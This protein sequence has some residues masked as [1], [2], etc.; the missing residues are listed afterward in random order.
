VRNHQVPDTPEKLAYPP[1]G[2]A[3]T[4]VAILIATAILSYTDRQ[5]LTLLVDPIRR[6]LGINDTEMSLLI[7]SAFAVIY[8]VAGIP[9]GYLVDRTSRRNLVACGVAIWSLATLA[10]GLSRTFAEIFSARVFVGLGEAVLSPAA[11]SLISD[12]FPPSRRG[13][14]VGLYLSGIAMGS[15]TAILI[16]GAVLHAVDL[17]V[18]GATPLGGYAPWRLVLLLSG[19]AGVAW[20]LAI[21]IIREPVRRTGELQ[22][23]TAADGAAARDVLRWTR[24]APIYLIVGLASLV[25]NAVGAWSPSLLIR[26]FVRDPGQIGIQLGILITV[27][28]GAGILLGGVLA[29]RVGVRGGLAAKLRVCL[30]AALLILPASFLLNA[31]HFL[32]VLFDVG[33]YF[34]LSGVVTAVGFSAILDN[35]PNRSRGLAIAISFFLNV[36]LGAGFGPTAVALSAR[37]LFG[38]ETGLG[39][40]LSLTA[41]AGYALA[42]ATALLTLARLKRHLRPPHLD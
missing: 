2:Y 36:A 13:T 11:L 21:L 27:G 34:A 9:L 1:R 6:D 17:G 23:P 30:V 31:P 16:G 33:V 12:Y 25:D 32:L 14:A 8:G 37:Y 22:A 19:L 3:W 40:A 39:P 24:V 35:V 10:C 4:V 29:D 28:G 18:L 41:G 15:G 38:E 7:G 42:G 5:V 26:E 20:S